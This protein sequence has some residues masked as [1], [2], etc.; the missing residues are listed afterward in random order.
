[1]PLD[2]NGEPLAVGDRVTIPATIKSVT[3]D[4]NFVNCTVELEYRLPP[5]NSVTT[6]SLNSRQVEKFM[7][8]PTPAGKPKP[9]AKK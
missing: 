3:E 5:T 9:T 1:M 7:G 8:P 6:E 4:P 2:Q